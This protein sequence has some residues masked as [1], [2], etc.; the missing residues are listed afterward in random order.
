MREN[1]SLYSFGHRSPP[2]IPLDVS[3]GS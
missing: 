3:C 1:S 2:V